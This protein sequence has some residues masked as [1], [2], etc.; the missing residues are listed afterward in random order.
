MAVL[1]LCGCVGSSLAVVGRGCFPVVVLGLLI[2][3]ASLV[4]EKQGSRARGLQQ[5]WLLG[6]SAQA[7]YLGHTAL[8]APRH[9]GSCPIR[10]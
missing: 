5:L 8:V 10:I 3:V 2:V 6:S 9:V 4:V 1:G 7:R